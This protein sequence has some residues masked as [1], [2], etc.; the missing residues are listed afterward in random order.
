[1]IK[2]FFV[3]FVLVLFFLCPVFAEDEDV[4]LLAR[5]SESVAGDESYTVM[6]AVSNVILNRLE[7]ESYPSSLGAVI[8]DAGIDISDIE[9]SPRAMRA[10]RD[11]VHGFDP[12]TGALYFSFGKESSAPILLGV[13]SWFFY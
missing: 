1:M 10:A 5:A 6:L 11:A 8:A 12:T 3:I 7:S 4:Y 9:P 13:D 2:N